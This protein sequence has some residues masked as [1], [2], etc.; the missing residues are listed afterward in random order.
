M[1]NK[2]QIE[3]RLSKKQ[4]R[5]PQEL[6]LRKKLLKRPL[7]KRLQRMQRLPLKRLLLMLLPKRKQ[8]K[9]LSKQPQLKRKKR[10]DKLQRRKLR[11]RELSSNKLQNQRSKLKK[12]PKLHWLPKPSLK[13]RLRSK[14]RLID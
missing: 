11:Q 9:R 2:L 3:I 10:R 1:Q 14:P 13:S 7:K 8:I 12:L 4:K 5:K 6:R